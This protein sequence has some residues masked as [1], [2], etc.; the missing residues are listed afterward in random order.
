MGIQR[1]DVN[2]V[3]NTGTISPAVYKSTFKG[4]ST[5]TVGNTPSTAG[6]YTVLAYVFDTSGN[7]IT[8]ASLY[9]KVNSGSYTRSV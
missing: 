9:Y 2:L 6:P 7:P 8:S 4:I 5:I 1:F 3:S